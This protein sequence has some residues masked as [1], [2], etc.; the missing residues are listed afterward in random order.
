V[1]ATEIEE[2]IAEVAGIV[3]VAAVGVPD[4]VLG[5]R[6]V[7]AVV[8]QPARAGD[9]VSCVRQH[10]RMNLPTF[11]VPAHIAVLDSIPRNANGKPDRGALAERLATQGV[12]TPAAAPPISL[13]R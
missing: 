11:M 8:T 12:A 2:V 13:E 10:A 5:Q 6:I 4:E 7:V 9:I 3:E 1:S